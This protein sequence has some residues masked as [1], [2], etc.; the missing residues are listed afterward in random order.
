MTALVS[1]SLKSLI[2]S[3]FVAFVAVTTS[4]PALGQADAC[5]SDLDGDG[6]VAGADLALVL[7]SWGPCKACDGD[8]NGDHVVD[9]VD[10]AFVLTRW[11]GTCTP[12]ATSFSP[13]DGPLPGGVEVTITGN[14]LLNPLV[15]TFGGTPATVLSSSQSSVSVLAPARVAG[16]AT[17]VVTTLG[18]SVVVGDFGYY[19]APTISSVTP[20]RGWDGGGTT[21]SIS[22]TGFCG[23]LSVAFGGIT[24]S[25]VS[26]LSSTQLLA[27]SPPGAA[28]SAVP[29]SVSTGSG[30]TTL[31]AAFTYVAITVP[32]WATPVEMEPDPTVV[33]S[34]SLREAIAETGLAWRVRD[35]GT[36]IEM[37][38]IPPGIFNM[39]C[40]ASSAYGCGPDESPVHTV[41]LTN[42]FYLG[43]HEVTQSQWLARMG[44]N[45][46][47]FQS[48]SAE[49]PAEQVPNRPVETISWNTVQ[50]FLTAT[51]MRLPTEAEWEYAYRAGTTTAYHGFTEQQNGTNDDNQSANI[52]WFGSCCG[53]NS[54]GQTRPVGGKAANG[55]GLHDMSG[56]V[57]EWVKDWWS[58]SYPAGPSTNPTGPAAGADR[59]V[60]G[61]SWYA[62]GQQI[63]S[64]KREHLTP[65]TTSSRVGFRVAR[66]P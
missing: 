4:S 7:G 23:D 62:A 3:V 65:V 60:R 52:A 31:P 45:P 10:L 35:S 37:V 9:G 26:V 66:N 2:T 22:G 29:I 13:T 25:A 17:V 21:V 61:G 63:R 64:S 39:G 19:G 58:A 34:S 1:N 16:P 12:T 47:S 44:S 43:R 14:H 54:G 50:G 18:G 20:T 33:L 49:V 57:W 53:G 30:V 48:P 36:Q 8:V 24:S 32:A 27:V 41:T 15:V 11:S 6:I 40:S 46:S 51:G 56:N 38:L 59:V 28:G 55:F 42:A 5:A